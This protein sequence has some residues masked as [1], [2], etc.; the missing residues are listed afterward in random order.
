MPPKRR[1]A[2]TEETKT[3]KEPKAAKAAKEPKAAKAAKEPKAAKAEKEPKTSKRST[4]RLVETEYED[5]AKDDSDEEFL[6][7]IR[8]THPGLAQGAARLISGLPMDEPMPIFEDDREFEAAAAEKE[9]YGEQHPLD[10][11]E[12]KNKPWP[13]AGGDGVSDRQ[14]YLRANMSIGMAEPP[15][16]NSKREQLRYARDKLLRDMNY[17]AANVET[18][19][20]KLEIAKCAHATVVQEYEEASTAY[21]ECPA[22]L[23]KLAQLKE[24]AKELDVKLGEP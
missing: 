7:N 19:V 11:S 3:A 8:K 15:K 12:F 22:D 6:T 18:A 16:N 10:F 9:E 4:K 14:S 13:T 21:K 2:V 20:R 1:T 24:L 23:E 5:H 17:A